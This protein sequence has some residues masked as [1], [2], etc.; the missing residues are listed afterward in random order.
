MLKF[1]NGTMTAPD[2]PGLGVSLDM[3]KFERYAEA[4]RKEPEALEDFAEVVA[5]M[6]AEEQRR[7]QEI[8]EERRLRA[9]ERAR[10]RDEER[11][12]LLVRM[13]TEER[14]RKIIA[15]SVEKGIALEIQA[16]SPFPRAKFLKF[17]KKMGAKFSFGTNNFNPKPKDLSRWLEVI[18]WLDLTASD[19]WHPKR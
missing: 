1:E 14:M 19:I 13:A 7:R 9:E 2:K 18:D 12:A 6:D 10:K 8:L 16:E 5:Q 3:D 4:N 15:K 17:A 11:R